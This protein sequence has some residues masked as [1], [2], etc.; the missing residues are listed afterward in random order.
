MML[1]RT[2]GALNSTTENF[3]QVSFRFKGLHQDFS[4]ENPSIGV[5]RAEGAIMR[6]NGLDN[7]SNSAVFME[8]IMNNV[9]VWIPEAAAIV[10]I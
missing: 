4:S 9:G 1:G 2:I 10:E 5:G 7:A 8:H 3:G 6:K